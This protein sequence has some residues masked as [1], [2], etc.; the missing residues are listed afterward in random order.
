MFFDRLKL[1]REAPSR[2]WPQARRRRD[3]VGMRVRAAP[4]TTAPASKPEPP[5]VRRFAFDGRNTKKV[6][7]SNNCLGQKWCPGRAWGTKNEVVFEKQKKAE[8]HKLKFRVFV[9]RRFETVWF[10][11]REGGERFYASRTD[12]GR[13]Q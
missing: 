6:N 12:G 1:R 2:R 11:L 3:G 4:A 5:R 8:K 10:G 7:D 13:I 9:R